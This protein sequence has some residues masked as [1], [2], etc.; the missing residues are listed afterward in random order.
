MRKTSEVR[1][2]FPPIHL[3][4]LPHNE[5]ERGGKERGKRRGGKEERI[6]SMEGY[7]KYSAYLFMYLLYGKKKKGGETRGRGG[8]DGTWPKGC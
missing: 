5:E 1:A 6:M 7:A 8:K 3:N 2:L 4:H